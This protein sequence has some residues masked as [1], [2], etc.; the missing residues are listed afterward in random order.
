M[1]LSGPHQWDK[2]DR[3][4]ERM[5]RNLK[6]LGLALVAVFAMSAMAASAAS[7][8]QGAFTA[9]VA[10]AHIFG[11]DVGAGDKFEV[12]GSTVECVTDEFTGTLAAK[13]T[14]LT[15]T[16]TYKNCLKN[17]TEPVTVTTNGCTFTFTV[18]TR[19]SEVDAHGSAHVVCPVTT[20]TTQIEVHTYTNHAAHTA[21]TSNC[22][23][24]MGSQTV[25]PV[26]YTNVANTTKVLVEGE[27]GVSVQTHGACSFG[28]TLNVNGVYK[29]GVE[30]EATGSTAHI[31]NL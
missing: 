5:I 2:S 30:V 26:T 1:H 6:T 23:L 12:L 3:K 18:G 25:E 28:L 20:P 9:G 24:T 27:L 22:T 13:S 16:P 19:T 4:E 21:G 15:I 14:D 17:G 29:A 11:T 8:T 31:G 10:N 7:A